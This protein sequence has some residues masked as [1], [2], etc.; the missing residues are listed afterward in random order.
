MHISS[1]ALRLERPLAADEAANG[2][3]TSEAGA[4]HEQLT[5]VIQPRPSPGFHDSSSSVTRR[6]S[7]S[8]TA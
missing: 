2:L 8:T 7:L 5:T 1:L 4:V 3:A 6:T